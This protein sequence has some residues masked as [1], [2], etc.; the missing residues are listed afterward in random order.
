MTKK[1]SPEPGARGLANFIALSVWEIAHRWHGFDPN[2]TDPKSLPLPVQDTL[3]TMCGD[4]LT[5]VFPAATSYGD[6][7]GI[8][9]TAPKHDKWAAIANAAERTRGYQAMIDDFTRQHLQAVAGLERCANHREYDRQKLDSVYISIFGLRRFCDLNNLTMPE[10]WEP[11]SPGEA[12]PPPRREQVDKAVCQG[13]ALTLW[14][15]EPTLTIQALVEHPAIQRYGNGAHYKDKTLHGWLAE[16][17]PRPK[18][19]KTGRPRK[20]EPD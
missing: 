2:T 13:I 15:Q 16:V 11:S 17:D 12:A 10:F 5:Q 6:D 14:E 18:E 4:L 19:A 9:S 8:A 20:S 7:F 3:R 1:S